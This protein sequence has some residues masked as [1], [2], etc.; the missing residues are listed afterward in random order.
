M[1][2]IEIKFDHL[3][4]NRFL[5]VYLFIYL[6]SLNKILLGTL[7]ILFI[8]TSHILIILFSCSYWV[9][10]KLNKLLTGL[11]LYQYY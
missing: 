4:V 6:I 8:T 10:F 3:T 7:L 2:K 11:F 9:N 5:N 1:Y